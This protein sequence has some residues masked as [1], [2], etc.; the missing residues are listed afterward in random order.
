MMY[1]YE[2]WVG[3]LYYESLYSVSAL[4]AGVLDH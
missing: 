2:L 1:C 3:Y 4:G